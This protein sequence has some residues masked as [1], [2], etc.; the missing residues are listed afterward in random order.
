MLEIF[1]LILLFP[2]LG[3]GLNGVLGRRFPPGWIAAIGC[4]SVALSFLVAVGALFEL[5]RLPAEGRSVTQS[6]FVWIQAGDFRADASFLLDP[7]SAVMILVVTG[8]GFLIHV[9]S[10]EYMRGEGGYYRYFSYLNLFIFM[11]SVLVLADN[12]LLMFVGW[13]GV[14]LCSYLLIGY[15]FETKV[16]GDAAKKAFVVNRIGDFGFLLGMFLLFQLFGTLSFHPLFEAAA[17]QFPHAEVGWGVLTAACLLLFVGATGKSAQIPL[18]VWLPDAMAGPTPVSALIHAATMVTAGVYM[19]ARS[20]ALYSRAPAAMEIVAVVGVATALL[21]A[22]I[23]LAQ[24]DIKRVL[25]YSTISQLGYMFVAVGVGAF[26]AGI[27]HLY[28]HAFF[29]ALLFLGS[30]SVILALHHEQDMFKMGGLKKY[31][32]FTWA[33]MGIGTLAIAG[34]PPLAGFFSKDEILWEALVSPHGHP[35]LWA[36]GVIVAAMTAFYMARL[37]FLT[38]YGS[39]RFKSEPAHQ[40]DH[41]AQGHVER[42]ENHSSP[43]ESSWWIRLPLGILAL[44]S[45]A[46]GFVGLPAWLGTNRFARFLEPAFSFRISEHVAEDTSGHSLEIGLTMLVVALALG[47]IWLAY[48]FYVMDP[49]RAARLAEA[50]PTLYR[51][52]WNKFYVDEVY[53]TL[54]VRPMEA[55]SRVLLW[56][57]VDVGLVDG[58]VNGVAAVFRRASVYVRRLQSGYARAYANWILLGAA[59]VCL[60]C[61]FAGSL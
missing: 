14:G 21:A 31:L 49:T 48:R 44:L 60:Y 8:V 53:D 7:L 11:M 40:A 27:F 9:Y 4:G 18:Y 20:S 2:L 16:A 1:P 36:V 13:E 3:A 12:Y 45:I 35:L 59:L 19:I 24:R 30:G 55:V 6:L 32:P 42:A 34:I 23:A 43:R 22:L 26:S 28:T 10:V 54:I 51:F 47:G 39:E 17:R 58:L 52:V 29:K 25:A 56:Q 5:V 15:Y 37:M 41:D 33:T 57:G 46:A 61:Y 38:F 50:H